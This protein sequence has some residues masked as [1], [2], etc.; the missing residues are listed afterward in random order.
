M[1]SGFTH[2]STYNESKE[3][4]TPRKIF[5]A[6]GLE[7]ELDPASPGQ[8][9]VPWIPAENHLTVRD[10]GLTAPWDGKVWLNPPYGMDTPS[11][12]KRLA[13]HK[14]GIALVFARTDVRWFHDY[15]ISADAICF[16]E[17]RI[18]FVKAPQAKEYASGVQ[19]QLGTPGAG[20]L[21]LAFGD[22]C[23]GAVLGC[24]LG[25]CIDNRQTRKQIL[26]NK[27]KEINNE[28]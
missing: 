27:M 24:G 25:W 3:W 8:K 20:S 12:L 13:V 7:F 21:L 14:N 2:E 16:I 1:T 15:A 19:L 9:I 26:Y 18:Q 23:A 4:Y 17:G 22:D 10:N 5:D 28:N 11:W 6:L